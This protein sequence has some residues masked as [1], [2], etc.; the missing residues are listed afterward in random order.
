V[1]KHQRRGEERLA[2]LAATR[3]A[4]ANEASALSAEKE[5]LERKRAQLETQRQLSDAQRT[6][7]ETEQSVVAL[8]PMTFCFSYATKSFARV[9]EAKAEL[10]ARGHS[11]FYEK[12]IRTANSA[13]WRKQWCIECEKAEVIINFLS[14][15]YVRSDSCAQE[16]NFS[17]RKKE[18]SKVINLLVGGAAARAKLM[19]VPSADVADSGGMAICLHFDSGEQA[20][21][22][23][24]PDDIAGKIL[25]EI[26]ATLGS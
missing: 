19:A 11:V 21:S 1:Q 9:E 12:S 18:A 15:D 7:V 22:V 17:K 23:Y 13:G 2:A 26:L 4:T 14:A 24:P 20:V 5:V 6:A 8:G 10:E 16:W 3:Q 25:K